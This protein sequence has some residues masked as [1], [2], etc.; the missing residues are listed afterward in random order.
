MGAER[1]M[2]LDGR[3]RT[4]AVQAPGVLELVLPP[5]CCDCLCLLLPEMGR[6]LLGYG[7]GAEE[8]AIGVESNDGFGRAHIDG[9]E[10]QRLRIERNVLTT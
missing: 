3:A 9:K 4:H 8:G 7:F 6:E 1:S 2:G 5:C 10:R